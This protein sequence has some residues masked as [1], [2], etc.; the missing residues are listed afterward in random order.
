MLRWIGFWLAV[1]H[2][3]KLLAAELVFDWRDM[4]SNQPPGFSS[5]VSGQGR[6]GSWQVVLDDA[7]SQMAR[8]TDLSPVVNKMPV[9]AQLDGDPTDERFPLL[10]CDQAVFQ[11]FTLTTRFKMVA[12]SREQMAG[13]A[14]RLQDEKNFY[15]LRASSL[16]NTLRF[17]KVVNGERSKMHGPDLVIA[18]GVWQEMK[19]ECKGNQIRCWLNGQEPL[20]TITDYSFTTG[21]F[22]FWTKSDAVTYY[23]ETRIDYVPLEPAIKGVMKDLVKKYPRLELIKVF[24]YTNAEPYVWI[25]GSSRPADLGQT[26]D[27]FA[28]EA[29]ERNAIYTGRTRGSITV[30]MPFHD[31]NSEVIGALRVVLK[32]R[33]T[34]SEQNAIA[35]ATPILKEVEQRLRSREDLGP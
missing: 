9:L 35:R 2:F 12:G 20:P 4:L 8:F 27:K 16:G 14:F 13:I 25:V 17:Y 29:I 5:L 18:K 1:G 28:R 23:G 32:A 7:P 19:I 30:T 3:S 6:K 11:D 26:G 33:F 31:R 34:D 21:K 24:S 22:G 10:V 15:V